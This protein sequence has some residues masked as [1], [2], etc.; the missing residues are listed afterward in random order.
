MKLH[1]N[2]VEFRRFAIYKNVILTRI[3]HNIPNWYERFDIIFLENERFSGRFFYVPEKFT[4]PAKN[5]LII[6]TT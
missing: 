4:K 3:P 2:E 5:Q 6:S 1:D